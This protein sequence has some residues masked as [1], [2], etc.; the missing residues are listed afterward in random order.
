[1][2]LKKE[3]KATQPSVRPVLL[4]ALENLDE[5]KVEM[6]VFSTSF[7]GASDEYSISKNEVVLWVTKHNQ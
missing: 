5:R 7:F 2:D 4:I 6:D 1:M 3:K